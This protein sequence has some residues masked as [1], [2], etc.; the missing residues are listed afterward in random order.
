MKIVKKKKKLLDKLTIPT[1][2]NF[3]KINSNSWFNILKCNYDN[4]ISIKDNIKTNKND[5]IIIRSKKIEI[6]FKNKQKK[7]IKKWFK[8]YKYT[9]N[10]TIRYINNCKPKNLDFIKIRAIIKKNFNK[11]MKFCIK[12]SKIPSH[13]ID[14]AIRDVI[15]AYKAAF[16][17][18]Q[19][20]NIK[21]F[22]IRYK[23]DQSSRMTLKLEGTSFPNGN[24]PSEKN[25]YCLDSLF[26]PDYKIKY[27]NNNT[28]CSSV[29]SKNLKTSESIEGI[30][31]TS[32]ITWNKR[33]NRFFLNTP[34]DKNTNQLKNDER[35]ICAIDPGVRTFMTVYGTKNIYQIG[36]NSKE[37]INKELNKIKLLKEKIKLNKSKIEL[38]KMKKRV[39]I[40]Q[41][42]IE[43]RVDDMHFKT[44]NFL[45]NNFRTIM[46][47][48]LSTKSICSNKN[49]LNKNTKK[50]CY[51]L[52][53]Y[54][55]RN[56]LEHCGELNNS[57]VDFV[58]E[59]YTSKTCCKCRRR[60]DSYSNE[61]FNCS[62]CNL[63]MNRDI[64]GAY[65]IFYKHF[66]KVKK[67][68]K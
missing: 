38:N 52:K 1:N 13:T 51:S 54:S 24:L 28:F 15:T 48:K 47:G 31:R 2:V 26:D 6:F 56:K 59:H 46:L 45:C 65:N 43:N 10:Q 22:R 63:K 62:F 14:E 36:S 23:K 60:N 19:Q 41:Q 34:I 58:S 18:L 7:I 64:M 42:K 30:E 27:N 61:I 20:G 67:Y 8:I 25:N 29:F 33:T 4:E 17:N 9:Y 11:E 66:E 50:Q 44:S 12:T 53:H 32:T 68:L 57:K 5:K 21:H 39:N 55:F 49:T 40:I 16:K 37:M 3:N 35:D